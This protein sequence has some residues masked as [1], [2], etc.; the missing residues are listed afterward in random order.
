[1]RRIGILVI[2]ALGLS[3]GAASGETLRLNASA[4]GGGVERPTR[5]MS[6]DGVLQRFGEPASRRGPVGDPPISTWE[7][8]DFVVYFERNHVIHAVVPPHR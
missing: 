8:G 1:M 7:Y 5:G 3:V 4:A 6:M 2:L